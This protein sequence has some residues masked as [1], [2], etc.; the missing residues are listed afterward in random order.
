MKTEVQYSVID[1]T[2]TA[3]YSDT[4]RTHAFI[5]PVSKKEVV[6]HF[7]FNEPVQVPLAIAERLAQIPEGFIVF[8]SEGHELEMV[9]PE[10]PDSLVLTHNQIVADYDELTIGAL[11]ERASVYIG[12]EAYIHGKTSKDDIIAYLK[13]KRSEKNKTLTPYIGAETFDPEIIGD[14]FSSDGEDIIV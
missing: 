1:R 4:V 9:K 2:I 12:H 13:M 8:D 6:Y 5:D 7:K 11:R 14:D 10:S 3:Q